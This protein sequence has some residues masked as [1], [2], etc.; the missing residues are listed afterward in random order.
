L[1]KLAGR[2]ESSEWIQRL[3]E[4]YAQGKYDGD[5][6]ELIEKPGSVRPEWESVLNKKLDPCRYKLNNEEL[7]GFIESFVKGSFRV[8]RETWAA[9]PAHGVKSGCTR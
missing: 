4:A 5:I 7:E 3:C 1:V 6:W 8:S 2:T 9:G